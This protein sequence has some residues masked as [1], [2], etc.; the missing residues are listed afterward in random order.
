MLARCCS[1]LNSST[2]VSPSLC[3]CVQVGIEEDQDQD[4]DI[5]FA[6]DDGSTQPISQRGV[7][8]AM[9]GE[10]NTEPSAHV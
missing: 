5:V 2:A 4:E 3:V 7:L 10:L 8:A 1:S 9:E 6:A